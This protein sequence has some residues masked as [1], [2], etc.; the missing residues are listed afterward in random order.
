MQVGSATSDPQP[1]LSGVVQGSV[2]GVICFLLFIND[3]PDSLPPSCLARQFADDVKLES[4]D[5]LFTLDGLAA[6]ETWALT[7]Q[8]SLANYK[9]QLLCLVSLNS[10]SL[11]LPPPAAVVKDL[12]VLLSSDLV[13]F[14]PLVI[15]TS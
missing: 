2:L 12:G 3:L 9:S 10:S 14:R 15:A 8:L 6:I 7:R 1:I 4:V 13:S 5:P 11:P